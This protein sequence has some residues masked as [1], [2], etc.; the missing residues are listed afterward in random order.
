[1]MAPTLRLVL[2]LLA[3]QSASVLAAP[4]HGDAHSSPSA[5]VGQTVAQKLPAPA[6]CKKLPADADWPAPDVVNK[7]LPG[8]EAP[9]PDGNQKHPDY[10][11]EVKTVASTQRAVKFAAKHNVRLSIINSG[12]D[13]L[14]R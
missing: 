13:F 14:G 8:W 4:Q 1:M 6:G 10:V 7:E 9:M 12:H 2:S 11:Y 5:N 3:I